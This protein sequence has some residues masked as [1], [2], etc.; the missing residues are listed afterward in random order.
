MIRAVLCDIEGTTTSLS[1]VHDILFPISRDRMDSYIHEHWNSPELQALVQT[2]GNNPEEVVLVLEKWIDEDKKEGAL[3]QIQGKI[4]KEAFECGAIRAHVYP[5]V[6]DS[7]RKWKERGLDIFIFS[8]GSIEAQ[9]LL[10][11]HTEAGDLTPSI[12]GYFDTTTGPKKD[13]KSYTQIAALINLEPA[14]LLFFSDVESELDAARQ[15]GLQTIHI[16]RDDKLQHSSH[17]IS[18]TFDDAAI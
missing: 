1:F 3:K 14:E 16:D 8:S 13:P 9:K 10:F 4:W 7:W 18:K 5:D 17:R 15:A 11:A 12:D 6:P 2:L